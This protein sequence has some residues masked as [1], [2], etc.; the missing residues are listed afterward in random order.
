MREDAFREQFREYC[1]KL[2]TELLP[3]EVM[4]DVLDDIYKTVAL[5]MRFHMF[6]RGKWEW[7]AHT[8]FDTWKNA[9]YGDDS[10]ASFAKERSGK[11]G[12]F[13]KYMEEAMAWYDR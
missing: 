8:D 9:V 2:A 4:L 12:Y 3:P 13:I 11:N 6:N 5:E 1:I 10:L 7:T